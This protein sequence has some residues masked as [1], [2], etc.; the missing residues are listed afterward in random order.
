MFPFSVPN[1]PNASLFDIIKDEK[2][3]YNQSVIVNS[4]QLSEIH[5]YSREFDTNKNYKLCTIQLNIP[6][7]GI[8]G[9]ETIARI[10]LYLDEEMIY[11]GTIYSKNAYI[12]RPLNLSGHK[13]NLQAG[14]HSLKLFAC[15][16]NAELHIPHLS[17]MGQ[18]NLIKPAISGSYLIIGY[19]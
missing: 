8:R 3:G 9:F 6:Y 1:F 16:S 19:N 2:I 15:T 11:D 4:L 12:L 13:S 5:Y 10:L 18:E 14:H 17:V 7:T